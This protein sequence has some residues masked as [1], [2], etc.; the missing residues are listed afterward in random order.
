MPGSSR[1]GAG[2]LSRTARGTT[3]SRREAARGAALR[4]ARLGARRGAA[5]RE[6]RLGALRGQPLSAR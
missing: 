4:E 1:G 3:A 2:R 6:A 5:R